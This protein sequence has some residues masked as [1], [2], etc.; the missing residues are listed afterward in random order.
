[1]VPRFELDYLFSRQ[2]EQ[3]SVDRHYEIAQ[4]NT[5][6]KQQKSSNNSVVARREAN[7]P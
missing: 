2:G 3:K 1:M 6:A 7:M 5:Y 4:I